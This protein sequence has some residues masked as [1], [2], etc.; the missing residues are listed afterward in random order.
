MLLFAATG[1]ANAE[2]LEILSYLSEEVSVSIFQK[3]EPAGA[4]YNVTLITTA[5]HPGIG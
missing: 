3:K 5:T 4:F 1:I 2:V